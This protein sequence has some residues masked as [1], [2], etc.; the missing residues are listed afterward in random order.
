MISDSASARWKRMS[1]RTKKKGESISSYSQS[2]V[3]LCHVVKLD[4]T[5]TKEQVLVGLWCSDVSEKS[6]R[7]RRFIS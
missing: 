1:E 2:K 6:F 3:K 4:E 7:L 5:D